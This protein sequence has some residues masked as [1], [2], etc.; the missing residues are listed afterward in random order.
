MEAQLHRKWINSLA[1]KDFRYSLSDSG[2]GPN[3]S[4][5]RKPVPLKMF[6]VLG[7]RIKLSKMLSLTQN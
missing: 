1:L 2:K 7:T 5:E 3:G 6:F 4:L